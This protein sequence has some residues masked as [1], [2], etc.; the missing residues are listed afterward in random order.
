MKTSDGKKSPGLIKRVLSA[1]RIPEKVDK[2]STLRCLIDSRSLS[3]INR[4]FICIRQKTKTCIILYIF[5]LDKLLKK[6]SRK[7]MSK[8]CVDAPQE[9]G[10][11][12]STVATGGHW[13]TLWPAISYFRY[14]TFKCIFVPAISYFRYLTFYMYLC[15][16]NIIF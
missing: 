10:H 11:S 12:I 4:W 13:T 2:Y 8:K 15:T 5:I 14:L 9:L 16:R 1:S 3:Y 7:T 6:A